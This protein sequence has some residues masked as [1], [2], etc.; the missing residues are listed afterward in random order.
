MRKLF[1]AIL[2]LCFAPTAFG[3][4]LEIKPDE[5]ELTLSGTAEYDDNIFN[6]PID[7]DGQARDW[8]FRVGPKIRLWR[9]RGDLT[10]DLQYETRWESFADQTAPSAFDHYVLARAGLQLGPRTTV[11][12]TDRFISTRSLNRSSFLVDPTAPDAVPVTDVEVARRRIKRNVMALNAQHSLTPRLTGT[13]LVTF[14]VFQNDRSEFFD[15]GTLSGTGNLIYALS[16]KD[17][18]GGGMG[19]TWQS[20]N[21]TD[22]QNGSDT[23][24]YRWF[25]SWIHVFDPSMTLSV[26]GGPVVIDS[27]TRGDRPTQAAVPAFPFRNTETSGIRFL[28]STTCPTNDSGTPVAGENCGLFP[29][30]ITG[31]TASAFRGASR[32]VELV[33]DGQEF[34]SNITFFGSIEFVKNWKDWRTSF[35]YVRTDAGSSGVGQSTV[36][37]ALT[38]QLVW[39]PD[40]N[41][42]V[43]LLA[44]ATMRQAATDQ[45]ANGVGLGPPVNLLLPAV[46]GF[47]V[48]PASPSTSLVLVESDAFTDITTYQTSMEVRRNIGRSFQVF[49]RVTYFYQDADLGT[50]SRTI[51]NFRTL[52]GFRYQ[53]A[54]HV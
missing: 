19:V 5:V 47:F 40:R 26:S 25:A 21:G 10:Y 42:T 34:G 54:L 35:S 11:G 8:V 27:Q 15:S 23:F 46:G 29:T 41:W 39:N 52:F 30:E 3:Q 28:D 9:G 53:F 12:F 17:R 50:T 20:F 36:L 7:Q 37:D 16:E 44:Q 14:S 45:V 2:V 18:V 49:G 4:L 33:D 51:D 48:T 1:V 43:R 13:G 24:F 38:A 22:T 32:I 6:T 31:T